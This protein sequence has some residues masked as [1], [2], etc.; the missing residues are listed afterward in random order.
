MRSLYESGFIETVSEDVEH[1]GVS[2]LE[3]NLMSL[4]FF[5]RVHDP[6]L[7]S[8][9]IDCFPHH[10]EPFLILQCVAVEAKPM[11]KAYMLAS[12]VSA[13]YVT[14]PVLAFSTSYQILLV[15]FFETDFTN[16][17]EICRLIFKDNTIGQDIVWI[18]FFLYMLL[19]MLYVLQEAL[20]E[21]V[22]NN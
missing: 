10:V 6:E 8:E 1:K 5:T 3:V 11:I 17:N 15:I 7:F 20:P 9:K 13:R 2:A 21:C 19:F 18:D 4:I 14:V 12:A 22:E 16:L